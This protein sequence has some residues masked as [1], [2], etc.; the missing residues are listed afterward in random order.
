MD[1]YVFCLIIQIL[2]SS[3][4]DAVLTDFLAPALHH[5][6]ERK[7]HLGFFL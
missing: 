5:A 6:H 7:K 3:F 2:H 4:C 1:G